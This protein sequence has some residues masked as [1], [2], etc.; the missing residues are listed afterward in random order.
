[1]PRAGP[2]TSV[3]PP[4][5]DDTSA[6]AGFAASSLMVGSVGVPFARTGASL[7]FATVMVNVRCA[8]AVPSET[9]NTTLF[10]PTLAFVGVPLSVAVPSPWSVMVSQDGFVGADR[11][12]VA[13]IV[14]L[15]GDVVAIEAVLG[16]GSNGRTSERG[17][18][19]V[20][21]IDDRA[22]SLVIA[23]HGALDSAAP[24]RCRNHSSR[25]PNRG[26]HPHSDPPPLQNL[27]RSLWVNSGWRQR[28]EWLR[29]VRWCCVALLPCCT[30]KVCHSQVEATI[31]I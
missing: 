23:D 26:G 8:V 1:M 20:V 19:I 10:G 5:S 2:S 12:H 28:W 3:I 15:R 4:S 31:A 21:I 7:T 30:Q 18:E 14:I 25:W 17:G 11:Q 24:L 13:R 29:L 6:P 27:H 16:G 22:D 9:S